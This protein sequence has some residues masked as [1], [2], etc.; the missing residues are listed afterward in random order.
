VVEAWA[1]VA[2][3]LRLCDDAAARIRGARRVVFEGA[4][5]VLLDQTWGFHPHTTWS[6]C[7]PA[8][9]LALA[10]DREVRRLGVIRG[11]HVRHGPGPFPT[12]AAGGPPEA[13]NAD[14]GWQGRFRTGAL[15]GVLLRYALAVCGGVDGLAVTCLDRAGE[16]TVCDAYDTDRGR[17]RALDPGPPGDLDHRERLGA[18]LRTVAPVIEPGSPVAFVEAATSAPVWM[19]SAGPT[20]GAKRWRAGGPHPALSRRR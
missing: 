10:G 1:E 15:D 6:D 3:R 11:Y 7:T 2:G 4:Q 16:A 18:W 20:A 19:V 5:G 17:V 8:G 14:L 9:A 13:H 12:E